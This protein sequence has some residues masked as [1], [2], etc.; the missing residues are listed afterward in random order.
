MEA[1]EDGD[2]ATFV[3]S[4]TTHFSLSS[5]PKMRKLKISHEFCLPQA[6]REVNLTVVAYRFFKAVR[7]TSLLYHF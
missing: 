2:E 5:S 4:E 6:F 7:L 3:L 1:D